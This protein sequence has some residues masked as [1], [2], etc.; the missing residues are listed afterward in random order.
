MSSMTSSFNYSFRL[1]QG[2]VSDKEPGVEYDRGVIRLIF[3]KVEKKPPKKIP[4]SAK[5]KETKK[6]Q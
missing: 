3:P 2:I 1:P 5:G 4:V 6:S